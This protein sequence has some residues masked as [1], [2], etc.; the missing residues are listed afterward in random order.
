MISLIAL[1]YQCQSGHDLSLYFQCQSGHDLSTPI[2][3]F[4]SK[5]QES[6]SGRFLFDNQ[7]ELLSHH[8]QS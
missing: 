6:D 5:F 2:S 8:N 7:E 1:D 4:R 3:Q